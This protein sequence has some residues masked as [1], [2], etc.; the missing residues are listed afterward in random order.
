MLEVLSLIF[1][2]SRLQDLALPKITC[3]A[4]YSKIKKASLQSPKMKIQ[5][6]KNTITSEMPLLI[7]AYQ[8]SLLLPGLL[9]K[10]GLVPNKL[11]ELIMWQYLMP[12]IV[13][14][15]LTF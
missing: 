7:K 9:K 15:L 12:T 2:M 3:N 13:H 5:T 8:D 10:V 11:V 4:R 14:R 6:R 1:E